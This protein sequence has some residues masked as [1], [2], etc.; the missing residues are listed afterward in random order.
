MSTPGEL[1]DRIKAMPN[2]TCFLGEF[3][4]ADAAVEAIKRL[5]FVEVD[6]RGM[7]LPKSILCELFKFPNRTEVIIGGSLSGEQRA[8]IYDVFERH[9]KIK[10]AALP[11]SAAAKKPWW[12][13]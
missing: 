8:E 4:S 12:K 10:A 7:A 2:S 6:Q 9:G 11:K 1:M 13:F 5:S 3:T